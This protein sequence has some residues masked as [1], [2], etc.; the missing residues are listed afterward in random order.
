MKYSIGVDV[1][2]SSFH[3]CLSRID[4]LQKV[5]VLRSG[6]FT[7]KEKGFQEFSKWIEKS[8][9]LP[10]MPL[11]ITM[12]ATG[13][14]YENLALFLF[15][16]GF[17]I[18]V[19]LPNKAKKYIAALGI[20]TKNDKADAQALSRMGAE[21]S[22]EVW[23]PLGEFFYKL[24]TL[25]R[26]NQSLKESRTSFTNQ[27][28]AL[29]HSMYESKNT[30]KSLE[31]IIKTIDVQIEINTKDISKHL[32]SNDEVYRRILNLTSIK[33]V[34]ELT[35][36]IIVAETNGF[37]LFKNIPQLVSY[38]GYDVVEN[39]SGKHTGKTKI[40]KKGNSRIRRALHMSSLSLIK[41]KVKVFC[42]LYERTYEKHKIKMKSYVAVQKKLL[43]ILFTL[44][45]KNEKFDNNFDQ[46][47]TTMDVEVEHSLGIGS[48]EEA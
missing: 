7:N 30:I 19:V 22:L 33:G 6:T 9:S 27:I 21:Q 15:L 23:E 11:F 45:K 5:K 26:H 34:G 40:S 12:E 32:S 48:F 46:N 36:A 31:K 1:S 8:C 4:E 35:A 43:S 13:V 25:T 10:S 16:N 14:Y 17:T 39:Q 2:K 47:K 28:E 18:S 38:S 37:A 29:S 42:N 44:W 3:V 20:K 41:Y 24:R